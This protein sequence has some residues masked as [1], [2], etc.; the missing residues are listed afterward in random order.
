MFATRACLLAAKAAKASAKATSYEL[1]PSK[2]VENLLLEHGPQT[3]SECWKLAEPAGIKSKIRMKA[4]L[5]WLV[6]R[7]RIRQICHFDKET[8]KKE[9]LYGPPKKCPKESSE[10]DDAKDSH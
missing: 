1:P 3:V 7:R 6:E 2:V 8:K 5:M 10:G 9:F 4:V